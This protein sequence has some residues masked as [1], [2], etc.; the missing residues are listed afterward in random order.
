MVTLPLCCPD[1][2]KVF[3]GIIGLLQE[4]FTCPGCG[5]D[6]AASNQQRWFLFRRQSKFGPYS[7]QQLRNLAAAAQIL[8]SDALS[9]NDQGPS[10]ADIASL[11][12]AAA[13]DP[14]PR[15]TLEGN[16]L[17]HTRWDGVKGAMYPRQDPAWA[18]ERADLQI[19]RK[20]GSGG[21]GTVYLAYLQSQDR[22]VALKV[23]LPHLAGSHAMHRFQR[24]AGM[25][26]Q[27]HHAN[28]V[29]FIGAGEDN[30]LPFFA[31]EYI[32]GFATDV[33]VKH[34]AGKLAVPDALHI[35]L[36]CA[37][38]LG[39]AHARNIVH[40]D[41]KPKNIMVTT[42]GK[43]KIA[44]LGLAKPLDEDLSLTETG[45][46]LGSPRYMAP[47]Q[48]RDAK[49]ADFRS[50]IYALGGVLY[51]F[52]TGKAP[53]AGSTMVELLLAKEHGMFPSARHCN[54]DVPER[55]SLM[56]DKMLAKDP[57]H[58]YQSC[59]D[60]IRDLTSLR[61]AGAHLSFNPLQVVR[62]AA[63]DGEDKRFDTVEILLIHEDFQDLVLVEQ[64]LEEK[65][66]A[67]N[68]TA[69]K[70]GREATAF[71]HREGR[72][73]SAAAPHLIILARSLHALG[74]LDFLE[75]VQAEDALR[76]IPVVVLAGS[77]DTKKSLESHRLPVSVS[78]TVTKPEDL[79]Q[80]EDLLQSLQGICLTVFGNG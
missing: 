18:L 77:E 33:L 10:E 13:P 39:Y 53:F 48:G 2:R 22:K 79:C 3:R 4:Q 17:D 65:G 63:A 38:A 21:M 54:T 46:T 57:R 6:P 20:A 12:S 56:I 5:L 43:I 34:F 71:L 7:W 55:L 62:H 42:L 76:R 64:A 15:E 47:E 58:R 45:L 70:D 44:D 36:K 27:L 52:L 1:C 28:I 69:V 25:L 51:F 61:L 35:I 37:A 40:R 31:M 72:F 59:D 19:L 41:I 30:G 23:L 75:E 60:L 29:E 11:Q 16:V 80:F 8:C 24:E 73:S 68:V 78:L 14:Q 74:I 9:C 50:D 66:I 26:A 49:R 32:E 67:K